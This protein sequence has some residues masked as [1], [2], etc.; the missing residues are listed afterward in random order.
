VKKQAKTAIKPLLINFDPMLILSEATD[1]VD[2]NQNCGHDLH[3]ITEN[4]Y[5]GGISKQGRGNRA[6]YINGPRKIGG[7]YF[8]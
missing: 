5:L 6:V 2:R 4:L 3:P 7:T 8:K 1:N